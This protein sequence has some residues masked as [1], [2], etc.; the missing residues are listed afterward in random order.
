M[1][2]IHLIIVSVNPIS[3]KKEDPLAPSQEELKRKEVFESERE[4]ANAILKDK[5][6]NELQNAVNKPKEITDENKKKEESNKD[7]DKKEETNKD[8]NKETSNENQTPE[9]KID[10]K[11]LIINGKGEVSYRIGKLGYTEV[12]LDQPFFTT[13]NTDAEKEKVKAEAEKLVE[14][15]KKFKI[16]EKRYLEN[17]GKTLD[18]HICMSTDHGY[19]VPTLVSMSSNCESAYSCTNYFC[20]N[21]KVRKE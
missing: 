14:E 1:I 13:P 11:D 3:F 10:E 16:E 7:N 18:I 21:C 19:I 4:K 20:F 9:E 17:R 2:F 5:E 6:M 15:Q 8:K 12:R